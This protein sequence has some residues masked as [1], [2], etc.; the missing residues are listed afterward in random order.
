MDRR[1]LVLERI[2]VTAMQIAV[3]VA[4]L[5]IW[6]VLAERGEID[7]SFFPEPSQIWNT[8]RTWFDDGTIWDNVWSTVWLLVSGWALGTIA[9][10]VLGMLLGL[11]RTVRELLEPFVAFFNAVP[12]LV[13]FPLFAVWFGFGTMPKVLFVATVVV[14]VVAINVAAGVREVPPSV[15][16]NARVLGANP[17]ALLRHVYLP[18]VGLWVTSTAR[19]TVGY[20]FNAAI[21]AEFVGAAQGLGYLI[22]QGQTEFRSEQIYA[23]LALTI[24]IAVVID[25]LL[26]IAERRATRW[27]P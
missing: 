6:Q 12:R 15:V 21:A 4:F 1:R 9:G 19:M 8:L 24:V 10:V 7:T 2:A 13:L 16:Q 22:F 14:F 25:G 23:A 27:M 26:S 11:S 3:V 18:A 5:W 17:F 20:A